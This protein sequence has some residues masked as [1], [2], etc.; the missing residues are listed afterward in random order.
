VIKSMLPDTFLTIDLTGIGV[1]PAM[2]K[3]WI[4]S[5]GGSHTCLMS[6]DCVLTP[7]FKEHLETIV[8]LKPDDCLSPFIMRPKVI[9]AARVVGKHWIVGDAPYGL[10]VVLPTP[11]VGAFLRWERQHIQPGYPHDDVRLAL[12]LDSIDKQVWYPV[13]TLC[14]HGEPTNSTIAG[15]GGNPA[16]VSTWVAG[17]EDIDWTIGL[18]DPF[19]APPTG[20]RDKTA[21][22]EKG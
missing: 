22:R 15:K 13:P 3:G 19:I 11:W 16:W 21:L 4:G 20:R 10:C 5:A 17:G 9:D 18:D 2:R 7:R 1:W 6:D 8:A 12:W 14:Q